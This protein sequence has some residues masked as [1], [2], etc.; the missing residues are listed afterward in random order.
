MQPEAQS[1]LA[2][3]LPLLRQWK[4]EQIALCQDKLGWQVQAGIANFYTASLPV[5]DLNNLLAQLRAQGVKLRDCASFGLPGHV[6][7][8]VLAPQG[9]DA[10]AAAWP[11]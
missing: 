3:S 9:Q 4:A 11:A 5:K 1:W 8:G 7:L 2:Q 10:L 6:R